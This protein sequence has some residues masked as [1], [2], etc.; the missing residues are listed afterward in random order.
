VPRL[1]IALRDAAEAEVQVK[2]ID[3]P[4]DR[5]LPGEVA[6]FTSRFE[7][8]SDAATGVVVTFSGILPL[9][10]ALPLGSGPQRAATSPSVQETKSPSTELA[11]V[12]WSAARQKCQFSECYRIAYTL[13]NNYDKSIKLIDASIDFADLLGAHIFGIKLL[14]DVRIEP[15]SDASYSGNWDINQF[16]SGEY[17]A[18][19]SA[20][21]LQS[22]WRRLPQ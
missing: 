15:H 3:P 12:K 22:I 20:A 11:L 13:R 21:R 5:L 19:R 6:H 16:R 10:G 2:T 9:S 18:S 1:R 17:V 8:P 14:E 7:H 4:K